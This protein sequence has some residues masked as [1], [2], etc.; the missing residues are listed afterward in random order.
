MRRNANLSLAVITEACALDDAGQKPQRDVTGVVDAAQDGEGRDAEGV[1]RQERFF[2]DPVLRNG[3]AR[4]G[5][6]HACVAREH[7]ERG[8]RDILELGRRGSAQ[9]GKLRQGRRIEI[10]GTDMTIGDAARR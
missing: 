6:R 9:P 8:R 10:V 7:F 3:N 4:R 1:S 2:A 5:R